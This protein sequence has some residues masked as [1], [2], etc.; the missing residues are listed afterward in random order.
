[1]EIVADS[2]KLTVDSTGVVPGVD[3]TTD[4]R[5]AV[6]HLTKHAKL[7]LGETRYTEKEASACPAADAGE[8]CRRILPR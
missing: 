8:I 3:I 1:M 6:L 4:G 7:L 2:V 5:K